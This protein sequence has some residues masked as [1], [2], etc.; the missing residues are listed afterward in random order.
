MNI[1]ELLR[2]IEGWEDRVDDEYP[3][4]KVKFVGIKWQDENHPSAE[5]FPLEFVSCVGA[6]K[7]AIKVKFVTK[8]H[9]P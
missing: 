9:N 2:E 4:R 5:E 8:P 7:N 1:E 3:S 6:G